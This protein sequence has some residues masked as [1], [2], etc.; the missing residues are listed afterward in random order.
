MHWAAMQGTRFHQ[1]RVQQMNTTSD[2]VISPKMR[3]ELASD[4]ISTGIRLGQR[5][6]FEEAIGQLE[7]AYYTASYMDGK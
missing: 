4:A 2:Q 3:G 1:R 7:T 5:C 6:S